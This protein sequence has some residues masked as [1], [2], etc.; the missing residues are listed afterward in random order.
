MKGCQLDVRSVA[1]PDS[2]E[3]EPTDELR[4][5]LI[6]TVFNEERSIARFIDSVNCQT[7]LPD[8]MVV[9]DGGS[10]DRTCQV[11][12]DR[13]DRR[14]R[15]NLIIDS[16][17]N[18]RFVP[19][20][21]ARGRNCAIRSASFEHILVT[22]AGCVLDRDWVRNLKG[23]LAEGADVV[24][25]YYQP[26]PGTR[27]Q[28]LVGSIFCPAIKYKEVKDFLPSSRSIAF[29]RRIWLEVGGYP[30]DTYTGEDTKFD[31]L[32][33]AKTE[34]VVIESSA[35]VFWEMPENFSALFRKVYQYG[36]GDGGQAHAVGRYLF[37][38]LC[39]FFPPL[40][41]LLVLTGRRK[42]FGY[43]V[44]LAQV[45]GYVRGLAA[46]RFRWRSRSGMRE[47]S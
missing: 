36:V 7:V 33:F 34:R 19:G 28:N 12:R 44:Y 17:C 18:R 11:I 4:V 32:L 22:D 42:A 26:Q 5:A 46:R 3:K 10:A 31:L 23:R 6:C 37:R 39:V 8:E 40:Y 1:V 2:T 13:L 30:E 20:P 29:T 25:G 41:L 21:I 47:N 16:T 38:A 15:L 27:F 43:V 24:S 14:V 45:L 9:V 35:I